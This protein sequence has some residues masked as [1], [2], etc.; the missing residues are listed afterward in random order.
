MQVPGF[1]I[2]LWDG[3]SS[4]SIN[5][6]SYSLFPS[7]NIQSLLA[8][9]SK[10][11][12]IQHFYHNFHIHK[13]IKTNPACVSQTI[14]TSVRKI[15]SSYFF[16]ITF[17]ILNWKPTYLHIKLSIIKQN[18]TQ[19]VTLRNSRYR[20]CLKDIPTRTAVLGNFFRKTL[21]F[22]RKI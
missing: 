17:N 1:P 8:K 19:K 12:Q 4:M 16:K 21:L 13:K 3:L 7:S 18:S 22:Y 14:T 20:T 10:N 6:I 11:Y 2:Q 5:C 9:S 15:W